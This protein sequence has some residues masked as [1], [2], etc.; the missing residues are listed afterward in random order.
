M[1][2]G[3]ATKLVVPRLADFMERHPHLSID[4]STADRRVD[5]VR[6]GFDCV[7]RSGALDDSSLV[8]RLLGH[9]R[10]V[11]CAS[12]DYLQRH[13][14]PQGLNDLAGHRVVHYDPMLGGSTPGWEWFDGVDTQFAPVQA[15]LTVNGTISYASACRAGLGII[16]V[17]EAGVRDHLAAGVLIE[18]LPEFRPAPMPVYFVYPSRRFVPARTLAFMDWLRTLLSPY[19]DPTPPYQ[20]NV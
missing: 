1:S 10:M 15:A 6:E 20:R 12:R 14:T 5:V 18:V 4:L 3:I 19:M 16:Q 11:N 7:L 9:Y 8:A 13:G 17:P 2:V